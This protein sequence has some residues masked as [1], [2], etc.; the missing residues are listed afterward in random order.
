MPNHVT[1]RCVVTGPSTDVAA[2]RSR[3]IVTTEDERGAP[4]TLLDFGK[5]IPM[6]K[7][8]GEVVEN[9]LAADVIALLCGT[10]ATVDIWERLRKFNGGAHLGPWKGLFQYEDGEIAEMLERAWPGCVANARAMARC[11]GETGHKSWYDW[12]IA[13]WGTKWNSYS[14]RPIS[15]EPLEFLFETAWAFP[16]PV[17]V[18]LAREYPSLHFNCL[19]FDEGWN[20]GARGYFNPPPDGSPWAKCKATDELYEI[21]YGEKYQRDPEDEEQAS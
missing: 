13:N 18:A 4:S 11:F 3:M 17:F 14:F 7:I 8:A 10:S 15:D 1:T 20:F 2:F 6:P 19:S 12:S 9:G 21:V 16:E 5:I